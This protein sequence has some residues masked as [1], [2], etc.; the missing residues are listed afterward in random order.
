MTQDREKIIER[1]KKLIALSE[2]SS[3]TEGERDNCRQKAKKLMLQYSIDALGE[4]LSE[5]EICTQQFK[6]EKTIFGLDTL[7]LCS[8]VGTVG[9]TFGCYSCFSHQTGSVFIMGF[10]VN[11]EIVDYTVRVLLN[12]GAKDCSSMWRQSPSA[13]TK[14]AFWKGFIFGLKKRYVLKDA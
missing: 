9:P 5:A 7:N 1:I 14:L 8:I 13:N 4:D 2:D 11:C 3:T 12:Q 10:K 6:L